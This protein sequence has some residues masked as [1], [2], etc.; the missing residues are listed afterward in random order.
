MQTHNSLLWADTHELHLG[1][2]LVLLFC[3][4]DVIEHGCETGM[5]NLD[6]FLAILRDR[7]GLCEPYGTD[8]GVREDDGGY[9]GV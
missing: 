7:L 2:V 6:G 4:E 5:V 8:F 1:G 3:R 9:V